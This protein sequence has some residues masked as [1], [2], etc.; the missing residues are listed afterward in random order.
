MYLLA[1]LIKEPTKN[2]VQ[3][4]GLC[5]PGIVPVPD[6]LTPQLNWNRDFSVSCA[7]LKQVCGETPAAG[8]QLCR[9]NF[10]ERTDTQ[11][12]N[13]GKANLLFDHQPCLSTVPQPWRPSASTQAW[14]FSS[15]ILV[16]VYI[17]CVLAEDRLRVEGTNSDALVLRLRRVFVARYSKDVVGPFNWFRMETAQY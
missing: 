7:F 12:S 2:A 15:L 6:T 4:S 14:E 9:L 8:L 11:L 5:L 16:C 17:Q 3:R 10:T 1:I 13:K